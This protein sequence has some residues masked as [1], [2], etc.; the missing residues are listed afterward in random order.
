MG[1]PPRT[2]TWTRRDALRLA[3]VG[4]ASLALG[5]CDRLVLPPRIQLDQLPD[6]STNDGFYRQSCCGVPE[7]DSATWTLTVRVLGEVVATLSYDDI[8]AIGSDMLE[9]TLQCIGGTPGKQ[10]ISNTIWTGLPFRDILAD[11]GIT[12]PASVAHIQFT[13]ADDYD[14][15]IPVTEL[16]PDDAEP[17][18][19]VWELGGEPLTPQHG[20]P[21]R[22]LVPGRYG[23]KNPKW[24]VDIHFSDVPLEGFWERR[25]WDPDAFVKA[26]TWISFPSDFETIALEENIILGS[27]FAGSDPIASVEVTTDGG[28]TWEPAELTYAPGPDRWTLW[29]FPWTPPSRGDVTI[30]ARC[31]TVG[32]VTS[33]PE[34][35]S[36]VPKAGF[37]GSMIVRATVV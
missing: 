33:Q 35:R 1:T 20:F 13:S 16:D 17:I 28:A 19:L 21:M 14:T 7:L 5:G 22:F 2:T 27:A 6:L 24:P 26:H 31:T 10:S 36:S 4:T 23:T 8:V 37:D 3:A 11:L 12:L 18:W 30:Q 15:S 9:L 29:R 25:G 32:G 34:S